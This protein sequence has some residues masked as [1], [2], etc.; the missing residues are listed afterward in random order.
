ML[1]KTEPEG[2]EKFGQAMEEHPAAEIT[3]DGEAAAEDAAYENWR[4]AR[5]ID[6]EV[7]AAGVAFYHE[8]TPRMNQSQDK[9]NQMEYARLINPSGI[10]PPPQHARSSLRIAACNTEESDRTGLFS[11][12]D[13]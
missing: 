2:S 4:R 5:V 1:S 13:V 10:P 7:N 8:H 6:D 11:P 12:D 3:A 9:T